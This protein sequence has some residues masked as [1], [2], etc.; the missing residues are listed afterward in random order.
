MRKKIDYDPCVQDK[1]LGLTKQRREL[2]IRG[3][4]EWELISLN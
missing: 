2:N 4:K 3:K 1:E